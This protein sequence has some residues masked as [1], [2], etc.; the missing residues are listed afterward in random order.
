[1]KP[2]LRWLL[3]LPA[4]LIGVALSWQVYGLGI[5]LAQHECPRNLQNFFSSY[6]RR[7]NVIFDN[8]NFCGAPWFPITNRVLFVTTQWLSAVFAGFIGFRVSPSRKWL[9]AGISSL[10][11]IELSVNLF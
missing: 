5:E 6:Y 9:V 8:D 1:M 7:F 4:V 11:A 2:L 10:L 3:L